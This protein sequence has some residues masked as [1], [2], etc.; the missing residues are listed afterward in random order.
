MER[1]NRKTCSPEFSVIYTDVI[2]NIR[3][4]GDSCDNIA[5]AVL[6]DINFRAIDVHR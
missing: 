5:N 3:K 1:L 4:I 2:N 6:K